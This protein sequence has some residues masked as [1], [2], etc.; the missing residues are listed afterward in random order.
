MIITLA[1]GA[2]AS[3]FTTPQSRPGTVANHPSIAPPNTLS[4]RLDR[5]LYPDG[6]CCL[7]VWKKDRHRFHRNGGLGL[8]LC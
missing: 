1:V 3:L 7:R 5:A 2:G 4:P 8:Q 6:L